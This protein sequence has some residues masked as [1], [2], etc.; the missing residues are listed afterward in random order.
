M[1]VIFV[2]PLIRENFVQARYFLLK[3]YGSVSE[4]LISSCSLDQYGHENPFPPS[5]WAMKLPV[6]KL[7][8]K[9]QAF[10]LRKYF[11]TL[12]NFSNYSGKGTEYLWALSYAVS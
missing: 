4:S 6:L 11:W 1:R 3:S 5:S 10:K 2:K 8:L 12:L 7:K 9:M